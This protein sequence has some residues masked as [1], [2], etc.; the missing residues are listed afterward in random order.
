MHNYGNRR[1]G[2]RRNKRRLLLEKERPGIGVMIQIVVL[3]IFL[4][5]VASVLLS[6]IQ[7]G[8]RANSGAD[9]A[10]GAESFAA[11]GEPAETGKYK[12]GR[13]LMI[14]GISVTGLSR[15]A[16]VEEIMAL[17]REKKFTADITVQAEE[18]A[19][20]FSKEEVKQKYQVIGTFST[21]ASGSGNRNNNISLAMNALDGRVCNKKRI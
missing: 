9:G 16:A 12:P 13:E 18:T 2:S 14:D 7:K 6:S 5:A 21:T 19:P 10:A 17:L 11:A 8:I 20:K 3:G 4:A 15:E 1:P